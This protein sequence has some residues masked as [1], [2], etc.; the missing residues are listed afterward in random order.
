MLLGTC[1][2]GI[3]CNSIKDPNTIFRQYGRKMNLN[4]RHGSLF[5]AFF[6][7]F[8]KLG[9]K[10]HVKTIPDD[11]SEF[12]LKLAKNTIDYREKH[13]VKRSDFMD[14]L[15][16]MK[17]IRDKEKALTLNEIAAQT[18]AFFAAGF[19][20]SA[21]TLIFCLFELAKNPEVQ[22]KARSVIKEAYEKYDGQITYEMMMDLPYI[23]QVL[24]GKNECS[25]QMII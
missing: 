6:N 23:D 2:F 8:K 14:I 18:F 12:V 5:F 10:L 13:D 1:A 21:T 20:T 15:I 9:R 7:G 25:I 11:V 16:T 19:E 22:T 4:A 24:Q 17:G 3:E